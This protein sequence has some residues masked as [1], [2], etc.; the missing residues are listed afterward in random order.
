MLC[1]IAK[2][3]KDATQKLCSL[4]KA[5]L[6]DDPARRPLYGHITLATYTGIA[7]ADFI[8]D[9]RR[10]LS[11]RPAFT[12]DYERLAVLEETAILTALPEKTGAL[13]ALHRRIAERWDKELDRWTRL[14]RWLPHTSLL[15]DP[16]ADLQ[17]LCLRAEAS[18]TPF[19]ARI[20]AI[21]FSRVLDSGY[22][23]IDR[24]ALQ[25]GDAARISKLIYAWAAVAEKYR[26]GEIS[27]D[28]YDKWRYNDPQYDDTQIWAKVPSHEF[29]D[30]MVKAFKRKLKE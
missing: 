6:G 12:V 8:R 3:D 11:G 23:I 14:E 7:E 15:Y 2:L 17:A 30:A 29:S 25:G 18:F 20:C 4:Q 16:Q 28:E 24:V 22:E 10:L 1:V 13:A 27:R 5:V 9:C 26:A 19:S 21:E